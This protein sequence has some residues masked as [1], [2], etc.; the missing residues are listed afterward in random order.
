[1]WTDLLIFVLGIAIGYG[2]ARYQRALTR[3][4]G[5]ALM[6]VQASDPAGAACAACGRPVPAGTVRAH[7]GEFLHAAC[8]VAHLEGRTWR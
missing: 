8:K 2:V 1:M 5:A 6:A 4:A 3:A 7:T